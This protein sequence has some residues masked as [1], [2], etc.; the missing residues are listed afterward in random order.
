VLQEPEP[1]PGGTDVAFDGDGHIVIARGPGEDFLRLSIADGKV[2]STQ[3]LGARGYDGRGIT[4]TP[5]GRIAY[6][7][8]R[9][10][11]HALQK[12]L[13]YE[14]E[15]SV[16][17]FVLDS[18]QFQ[19]VWGRLFLDACVP[20][21]T[22]LLAS[23]FTSDELPG[24]SEA[25]ISESSPIDRFTDRSSIMPAPSLLPQLPNP[26]R[27]FHLRSSGREIPWTDR[28]VFQG[29][30]TPADE[31]FKTYEAPIFAGPGRY[32]WVH[33]KLVG[34]SRRTPEIKRLR[35][36]YPSHDLL[37]RL[38]RV[39]S[40]DLE[41][42]DFLRRFLA[43]LD[44]FLNNVDGRAAHRSVLLHPC[45]T[46]RELL[47]WLAGFVGLVLDERWPE[48]TKRNLIAMAVPLFRR[49]GT[50]GGL[51]RFLELYT[52]VPVTLIEHFKLRGIGGAILGEAEGAFTS[53]V[54]GFGFRVGGAVDTDVPAPLSGTTRNAF[55]THAHRF[56]VIIPATLSEEQVDV[57]RHII[58]VHRPAHTVFDICTAGA[59]MRIGR[60][61]HV[62]LSSVIGPTGGF[63]SAQID[64][65]VLG[66]NAVLG[67][68]G[69]ATRIGA[70]RV[71]IDTEVG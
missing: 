39:F 3:P 24:E 20:P 57:V 60:G 13:Q 1:V 14:R 9:G 27:P 47:P 19:M 69:P 49:R 35:A 52:E 28:L 11:R 16:T 71:G 6:W 26:D 45:A 22:R 50:V 31:R 51:K 63:E 29:S 41:V 12:R 21:G 25:E 8:V 10:P 38:P 37:R 58:D 32:L 23:Y 59:G 70:G 15:G 43:S 56:T 5:S 48:R 54:L 62:G 61:L 55:E 44:G 2:I 18:G 67:R 7:S 68:P 36:E 42:A 65:M 46:P 64:R 33:I 53:S 30:H 40:R 17:T 4:Q 34:T 66:W